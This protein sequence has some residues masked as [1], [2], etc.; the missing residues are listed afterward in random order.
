MRPL[1]DHVVRYARMVQYIFAYITDSFSLPAMTTIVY[2]EHTTLE[3]NE[4]IIC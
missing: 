3:D 1:R 2:N 4:M